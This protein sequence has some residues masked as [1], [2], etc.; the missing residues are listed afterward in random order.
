M[1]RSQANIMLKEAYDRIMNLMAEEKWREAHRACLEILRFDPDNIK[2]IRLKN[3]IE[4]NVKKLN[5]KAVRD[6]ID[7]LDPLWKEKRYEELLIHLKEL[8]PYIN[9]YPPL[10]KI[11]IKAEGKYKGQIAE[12]QEGYFRSEKGR[13]KS[14][15]EQ[16]NY[17]EALRSA[18]KLRLI[19]L[20]ED[21]M[22]KMI[23]DMRKSWIQEEIE[24]SQALIDSEKY[25]DIL[26]FYQGLLRI[27]TK[28]EVLKKRI[29]NTK[30]VYEK[31][32]IEQR[33]E[34]IYKNF[35]KMRT[36]FQL[37]KYDKALEVANE[38]LLLDPYNKDIRK[39]I[40]H[41]KTKEEK[42]V[43]KELARQIKSSYRQ[44]K[45]DRKKDKKGFIR[46]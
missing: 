11:I 43:F 18:E 9:D 36:L 46:L 2:I 8:E 45:E 39:F 25:E 7:K 24:R 40:K 28:S 16:N 31:Y 10:Q 14:L 44:M 6:D 26:L 38:N 15:I 32:K 34:T 3:K 30:K 19:G 17:Q 21:E 12:Q 13:I 29:A 1:E 35:E 22:K 5:Y 27:D 33:R 42:A 4:R 20:H 37:K 41:A 23:S